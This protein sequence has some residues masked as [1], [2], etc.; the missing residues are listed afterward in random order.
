MRAQN[1]KRQSKTKFLV[2]YYK[3]KYYKIK[4]HRKEVLLWRGRLRIRHSHSF[5][6]VAMV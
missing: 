4:S 5:A 6:A 2:K 3:I 1:E